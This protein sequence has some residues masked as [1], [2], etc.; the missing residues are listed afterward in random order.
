MTPTAVIHAFAPAAVSVCGLCL[1]DVA[2]AHIV[3]LGKCGAWDVLAGEDAAAP[4]C[5]IFAALAVLTTPAATVLQESFPH[6]LSLEW[7]R[8]GTAYIQAFERDNIAAALRAHVT[9]AFA[10]YL[11]AKSS[12]HEE[13]LLADPALGL[14]AELTDFLMHEYAMSFTTALTMPIAPAFVLLAAAAQRKGA[15]F[16]APHYFRRDELAREK[17]AAQ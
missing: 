10:S 1:H 2:A 12:A 6:A 14:V 3:A 9:A 11:P 13:T 15:V 5:A 8:A 16:A 17:G 7:E 4:R